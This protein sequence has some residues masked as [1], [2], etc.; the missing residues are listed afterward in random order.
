MTKFP[1]ELLVE[2]FGYLCP[3]D[4]CNVAKVSH[5]FKDLA[6]PLLYNDIPCIYLNKPAYTC[7]VASLGEFLHL[8]KLVRSL[9]V[10]VFLDLKFHDSR[11]YFYEK[12]PTWPENDDQ[13][14]DRTNTL[15][16]LLPNLQALTLHLYSLEV[17]DEAFLK[18]LE[19]YTPLLRELVILGPT[20][21][22]KHNSQVD[23]FT[24]D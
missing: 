5:I 18:T 13:S 1:A 22:P 10:D 7:F 8:G 24:K 16:R 12:T 15:L 9:V 19:T 6:Q 20:L 23:V 21:E 11:G 4:L 2:I 17:F 14:S 3:S